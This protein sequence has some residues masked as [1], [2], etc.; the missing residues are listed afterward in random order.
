MSEEIIR[1]DLDESEMCQDTTGMYVWFEDYKNHIDQL[2]S[3]IEQW[4]SAFD[5]ANDDIEY[6]RKQR[7]EIIES[8]SAKT[9]HIEAQNKAMMEH[10]VS[11]KACEPP[12][13][14]HIDGVNWSE[15]QQL[16]SDLAVLSEAC[17]ISRKYIK[18]ETK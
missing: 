14:I 16:K 15:Y 11:V 9:K 5:R 4:K 7:G 8:Y 2:K 13:P 12:A 18:G 3:E 1:Y 6:L 10:I 17:T